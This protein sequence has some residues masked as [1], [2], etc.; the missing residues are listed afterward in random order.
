MVG[1]PANPGAK[2]ISVRLIC[3]GLPLNRFQGFDGRGDVRVEL[4]TQ[5]G[6]EPGQ[7][8]GKDALCWLTEIIV[9]PDADGQPDF[10]GKAVH[11]K[12]GERFFYLSWSGERGSHR[13]MFRRIKIHLRLLSA[14]QLASTL[15]S[16]GKLVARVNALAKDGGPACASVALL[17]GGWTVEAA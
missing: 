10:S 8:L 11:G 17:G 4:Q 1:D 7:P 14:S 5:D 6:H 9:K 2:A 16:G 13:E 3:E 15:T 12:R